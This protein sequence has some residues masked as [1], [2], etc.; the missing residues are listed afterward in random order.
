MNTNADRQLAI[1]EG[2]KTYTGKPCKRCGT[3]TKYVT[4]Y[5]C[6]QCSEEISSERNKKHWQKVKDLGRNLEYSAKQA[7]HRKRYY[8]KNKDKLKADLIANKSELGTFYLQKSLTHIKCKSKKNNIPFDISVEDLIIPE[9]CPILGIELQFNIGGAQDNSPS[10]DRIVPEL[11][12][13]PGNVII[14]SSRA[15]RIK[16]NATIDEMYKIYSFYNN[17]KES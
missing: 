11:G 3:T 7:P 2:R 1:E 14:I 9:H 4:N 10:I 16:N 13:V 17:L 15:N 12:Y 5:A 6:V 8:D